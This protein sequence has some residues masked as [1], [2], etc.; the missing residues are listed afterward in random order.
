[1]V[2]I[3]EYSL[4]HTIAAKH[5]VSLKKVLT[6]YGKPISTCVEGKCFR[7]EKPASLS[8]AYLNSHYFKPS[9]FR[10]LKEPLDPFKSMNYD[11]R[12]SNLLDTN[13]KKIFFLLDKDCFICKSNIRVEMHHIRHLKDVKDKPTLIKIMSQINRKVLPLCKQCHVKVH[14]GRYDGMNLNEVLRKG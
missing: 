7:F 3:L 9:K 13:K 10:P 12:E 6:L 5:R 14:A 2:Y 4:A 8:A 1:M 11:L